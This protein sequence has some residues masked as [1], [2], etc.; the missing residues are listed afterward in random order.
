MYLDDTDTLKADTCNHVWT[1]YSYMKF[2]VLDF[3]VVA[4]L[5]IVKLPQTESQESAKPKESFSRGDVM[6]ALRQKMKSVHLSRENPT[7]HNGKNIST[8]LEQL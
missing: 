1:I 5:Q 8:A 3:A 2:L 4:K 6:Q 7:Y